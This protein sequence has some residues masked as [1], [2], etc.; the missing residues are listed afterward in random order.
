MIFYDAGSYTY[1]LPIQK[2]KVF[3]REFKKKK[4]KKPSTVSNPMGV[5]AALDLNSLNHRRLLSS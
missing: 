5:D 3:T 2:L 1:L 4:K